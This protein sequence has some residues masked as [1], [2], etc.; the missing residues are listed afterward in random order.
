[1]SDA[2]RGLVP[3]SAP[4]SLGRGMS[5][6]IRHEAAKDQGRT[7]LAGQTLQVDTGWWW[8]WWWGVI[9]IVSLGPKQRSR[10]TD[11]SKKTE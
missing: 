3:E 1:M 7:R 11:R 9:F 6:D 8:W 2:E 10:I 5:M 4:L